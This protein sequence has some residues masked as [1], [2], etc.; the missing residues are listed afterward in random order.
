[1]RWELTFFTLPSSEKGDPSTGAQGGPLLC[2][3]KSVP[4][5]RCQVL[6]EERMRKEK[7][8]FMHQ[9]ENQLVQTAPGPGQFLQP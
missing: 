7:R 3:T 8:T 6:A 9:G 5:G 4:T 1:M 2:R